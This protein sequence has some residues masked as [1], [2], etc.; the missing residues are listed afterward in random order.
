MDNGHTSPHICDCNLDKSG[1]CKVN[2][3][4]LEMSWLMHF[5]NESFSSFFDL[6]G[7]LSIM[8]TYNSI[9]ATCLH[10]KQFPLILPIAVNTLAVKPEQNSCKGNNE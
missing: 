4:C 2:R 7:E 3:R 8:P 1:L 9:N 6:E 5:F 10:I